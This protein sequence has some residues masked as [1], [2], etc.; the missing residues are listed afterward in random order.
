MQ[1]SYRVFLPKIFF[2][3]DKVPLPYVYLDQEQLT[4]LQ[5]VD[6]SGEDTGLADSSQA[7]EDAL[8]EGKGTPLV[9]FFQAGEDALSSLI[10][11]KAFCDENDITFIFVSCSESM[12][13]EAWKNL[14][15][16]MTEM[17]VEL[18]DMKDL[19][20]DRYKPYHRHNPDAVT[21]KE[22]YP[23][24]VTLGNRCHEPFAEHIDF[25][26]LLI[27]KAGLESGADRVLVSDLA[28]DIKELNL[29]QE[30]KDPQAT[31]EAGG[32][33][34][35]AGGAAAEAV[36]TTL[37]L[38]FSGREHHVNPTT[39]Y[40]IENALLL[41]QNTEDM[42]KVLNATIQGIY[43][44]LYVL[45]LSAGGDKSSCYVFDITL[46]MLS[47]LGYLLSY[48]EKDKHE[49]FERDEYE[50]VKELMKHHTDN[51]IIKRYYPYRV[52]SMP[53]QT[54]E[55]ARQK[56][57]D[58]NDLL[59]KYPKSKAEGD[60]RKTTWQTWR[61]LKGNETRY[62]DLEQAI[63]FVKNPAA[64]AAQEKQAAKLAAQG[65][66]AQAMRAQSAAG[67][68]I[69]KMDK[70]LQ[71]PVKKS[72]GTA[73]GGKTF[74]SSEPARPSSDAGGGGAGAAPASTSQGTSGLFGPDQALSSTHE[75]ITV[76]D[77]IKGR[78]ITSEEVNSL[79]LH[80]QKK[81]L[82]QP[83]VLSLIKDCKITF[84]DLK[85]LHTFKH[86]EALQREDVLAK[87]ES[88]ELDINAVIDPDW[89][90]PPSAGGRA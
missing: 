50:C 86:S 72:S 52:V 58:L 24:C 17:G 35:E 28:M 85:Q 80:F 89:R 34:A 10:K 46:D 67:S 56:V 49:E 23:Y 87:L 22:Y 18:A 62:R 9:D 57:L 47:T 37:P 63:K 19:S 25:V 60:Y 53:S 16:V 73:S 27:L 83:R 69:S 75:V 65:A 77:L 7:G 64:T 39:Y 21:T 90:P 40:P 48:T 55:S 33:A 4:E 54:R 66:A 88:G 29:L 81:I 30:Q 71:E 20:P 51:E 70:I 76:D 84:D 78:H 36:T 41:A 6:L 31:Q 44:N 59:E 2:K 74:G 43:I 45:E 1:K 32:A 42:I 11:H 68:V 79:V 61:S 14:S 8:Q 3:E 38:A 13:P 82:K 5:D 15:D 12:S 26:K